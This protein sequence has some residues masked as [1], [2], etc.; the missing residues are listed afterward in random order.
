MLYLVGLGIN[1]PETI[2]C[3]GMDA[4]K[5]CAVRLLDSYTTPLGKEELSALSTALGAEM[6]GREVLEDVNR[7]VGLARERD[8]CVLV[9]GD[10]FLATTHQALRVEALIRG[11]AVKVYY[12]AGFLNA[13]FGELGLHLYKLGSI[14]TLVEGDLGS[15]MYV[16]REVQR[17]LALGKHSTVVLAVKGPAGKALEGLVEA[18]KNYRAGVFT[19]DRWIIAASRVGLKDESVRSFTLRDAFDADLP[20]PVALIVPAA[21]HFTEEEALRARHIQVLKVKEVPTEE[22]MRAERIVKML[23]AVLPQISDEERAK[24]RGLVENVENYTDDAE[25]YLSQK[26]DALA[27]M[28]AAYAEGLLDSLRLMGL[29]EIR[30]PNSPRDVQ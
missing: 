29:K 1:P 20:Q 23:R 28:Q 22:R 15:A 21:L 19:E 13:I 14:S 26:E 11:V 24:L 30:W 7:I 9:Y 4:I 17:S 2:P 3:G 25:N 12:A 27:L 16:Y 5:S 18:E 10:P 6:A 8:V